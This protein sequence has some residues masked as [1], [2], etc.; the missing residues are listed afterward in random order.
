MKT[1]RATRRV[2]R[3]VYENVSSRGK[4]LFLYKN[5]PWNYDIDKYENS[6]RSERKLFDST[7][8]MSGLFLTQISFFLPIR[9]L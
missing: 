8:K 7:K 9:V 6:P 4:I 5:F 2:S 3:V 1:A